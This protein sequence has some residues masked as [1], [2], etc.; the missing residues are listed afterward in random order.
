M[1]VPYFLKD[2]RIAPQRFAIDKKVV[3]EGG[4]DRNVEGCERGYFDPLCCVDF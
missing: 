4:I 2:C 1:W 3:A